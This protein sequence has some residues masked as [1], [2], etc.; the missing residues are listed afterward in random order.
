MSTRRKKILLIYAYTSVS[1]TTGVARWPP[2][3]IGYIASFLL[4]EG[5]S[6]KIVDLQVH[7]ERTIFEDL[8]FDIIGISIISPYL[9]IG[10]KL[11]KAIKD[12]QFGGKVI[13]GGPHVSALPEQS[14]RQSGADLAC[15]GEG[16]EAMIKLAAELPVEDIKGVGW[17]ENGKFMKTMVDGIPGSLDNYPFPAFHLFDL[18]R[19]GVYSRIIEQPRSKIAIII[20]S[21]GCPFSCD[22]C[23]KLNNY[24]IRFRSPENIISEIIQLKNRFGYTTFYFADDCFNADPKRAKDICR[25]I[26]QKKLGIRF[27]LPNGI[28]GDLL[29][30]ELADLMKEAGCTEANIG[31]ESWDDTVRFKMGKNLKR[32]AVINAVKLLQKRGIICTAYFIMGHYYDTLESLQRNIDAVKELDADF[33]QYTKFVPM[34]GSPIYNRIVEERRIKE[35]DFSKFSIWGSVDFMDHPRLSNDEIDSAIKKAYRKTAFRRRVIQVMIQHP[36]IVR[37][38]LCNIGHVAER[39]KFASF[40]KG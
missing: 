32:E 18:K 21:R 5:H 8:D 1:V 20:T 12:R 35:K 33:F 14:L 23:F 25:R 13:I 38:L 39:I 24:R 6:V 26:I 9:Q 16:E 40:S 34:P 31:V 2:L 19:Y 30:D 3:G 27:A 28:R 17:I 10:C 7:P 11:V 29:D 22:F 37:N 36:M 4:Q 15:I